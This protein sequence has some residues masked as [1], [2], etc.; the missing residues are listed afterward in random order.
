MTVVISEP[1]IRSDP[2]ESEHRRDS[3]RSNGHPFL[4]VVLVEVVE[5]ERGDA[6]GGQ[7]EREQCCPQHW[8]LKLV[9]VVGDV[10]RV[11][12]RNSVF[13]EE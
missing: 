6:G 13:V 9:G 3:H 8:W 4:G 11:P 1:P 2:E 5:P 10:V 12:P 7:S